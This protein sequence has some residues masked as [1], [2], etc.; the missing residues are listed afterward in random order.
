[1]FN[2]K[3]KNKPKNKDYVYFF[4]YR[5]ILQSNSILPYYRTLSGCLLY[6][7]DVYIYRVKNVTFHYTAKE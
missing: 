4:I 7:I 5:T 6:K 1:M 2:K 3:S